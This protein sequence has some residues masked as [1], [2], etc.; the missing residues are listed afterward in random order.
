M[1]LRAKIFFVIFW[2]RGSTPS[3][4]NRLVGTAIDAEGWGTESV[5]GSNE[6]GCDANCNGVKGAGVAFGSA[7]VMA[8]K[9]AGMT[10][11]TGSIDAGGIIPIVIGTGAV[12]LPVYYAE[13]RRINVQLF[14]WRMRN[15]KQ[16]AGACALKH[17]CTENERSTHLARQICMCTNTCT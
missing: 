12:V 7:E 2:G 6:L 3:L 5:A 9:A 11:M 10:G 4:G 17:T 8:A 16:G 15:S 13:K 1:N 14:V